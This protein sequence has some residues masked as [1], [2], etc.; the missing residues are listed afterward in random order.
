VQK[1]CEEKNRLNGFFLGGS[2]F[3][4]L[5]R[6]VKE[7]ISTG[8]FIF[9]VFNLRPSAQSAEGFRDKNAL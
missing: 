2:R 3:T 4:A 7:M 9:F 1:V 8:Q 5:K 6:G